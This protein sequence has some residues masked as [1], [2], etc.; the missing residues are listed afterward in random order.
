MP[1]GAKFYPAT[2]NWI[3]PNVDGTRIGRDDK[4]LSIQTPVGTKTIRAPKAGLVSILIKTHEVAQGA[5]LFAVLGAARKEPQK[6]MLKPLI[7]ASA[8][9]VGLLGLAGW[10]NQ[11][12]VQNSSG[13]KSEL[14]DEIEPSSPKI[15]RGNNTKDQSSGPAALANTGSPTVSESQSEEVPFTCYHVGAISAMSYDD[16]FRIMKRD[17]DRFARIRAVPREEYYGGQYAQAYVEGAIPF[18]FINH[19][20]EDTRYTIAAR[21]VFY[22]YYESCDVPELEFYYSSLQEAMGAFFREHKDSLIGKWL[23]MED[24]ESHIIRLEN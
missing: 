3:A 13:V 2:V 16:V 23:P 15:A 1:R 9:L 11:E 6:K 22:N 24:W 4:I 18:R 8:A 12:N 20:I 5:E 19:G 14:S 17:E 10:Q 7:F 21:W